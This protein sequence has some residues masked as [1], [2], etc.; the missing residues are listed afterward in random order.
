MLHSGAFSAMGATAEFTTSRKNRKAQAKS[1]WA[2]ILAGLVLVTLA[3]GIPGAGPMLT[4]SATETATATATREKLP[5]A[6]LFAVS[7]PGTVWVSGEISSRITAPAASLNIDVLGQQIQFEIT[8][9]ILANNQ[10]AIQ[11]R[12]FSL[13]AEYP[14]E[15]F[16]VVDEGRTLDAT[17]SWTGSGFIVD[18]N[19]YIVTNAHVAAPNDEE[20][21]SQLL[22]QGLSEP[23][24]ADLAAMKRQAQ[25]YFTVSAANEE[26]L[27]NSYIG[28]LAERMTMSKPEKRFSVLL[29]ANIPGVATVPR[30]IPA[31]V[32]EAGA[33]WPGK[34][35]AIIKIDEK[36]LPTVPLGDDTALQTGDTLYVIGYPGAGA[37]SEK[38]LTE[39]T[40][41][42]GTLSGRKESDGG[43]DVLQ[44]D[45]Q[46]TPGNS[47]GPVFNDYGHV[48][49]MAT[50][51]S[52]DAQTGA[53]TGVGF[54]MTASSI[55]D[56]VKQSGAEPG[57]GQFTKNYKQ[58]LDLEAASHHSAALE[59]FTSLETLSPGHPYVQKHLA[60]NEAAVAAGKDVPIDAGPVDILGGISSQATLYLG[61]AA[62]VLLLAVGG[63][64]LIRARSTNKVAAPE[65]NPPSF[66]LPNGTADS[67]AA[68]V[69]RPTTDLVCRGCGSPLSDGDH[70]CKECGTHVQ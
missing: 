8:D 58:G 2:G 60:A 10:A 27:S 20:L 39:P 43:F 23:I 36:N 4:A 45:A 68:P 46:I 40:F 1:G 67:G 65:M 17:S 32:V 66:A 33:P 3:A 19:G 25:E 22:V 61:A 12:F 56:F 37:V 62:L 38:S 64:F 5:P 49:G 35:V 55:M 29:G 70:F 14:D 7:E 28:W 11:D 15:V 34:D 47:G 63:F 21:E 53:Q 42:T 18:E 59:I 50:F 41:T 31:T 16:E 6:R 44:T 9:G 48:V 51:V 24:D 57:E 26:T 52:V 30:S 69:S 13:I 54:L